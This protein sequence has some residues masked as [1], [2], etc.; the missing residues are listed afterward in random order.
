MKINCQT[1]QE[2]DRLL[3]ELIR[4]NIILKEEHSKMSDDKQDLVRNLD[5]IT[6]QCEKMQI[7]KRQAVQKFDLSFVV[8]KFHFFRVL[9]SQEKWNRR[10][11]KTRTEISS[12][13]SRDLQ[14]SNRTFGV[15][16]E[17]SFVESEK[18]REKW[19]S[20]SEVNLGEN[21]SRRWQR[22]ESI[23]PVEQ[24]RRRSRFEHGR[25]NER[26]EE[27]I[28]EFF[29]AATLFDA[30]ILQHFVSDRYSTFDHPRNCDRCRSTEDQQTKGS[31]VG[32]RCRRPRRLSRSAFGQ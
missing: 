10:E 16:T 5:R 20:T 18:C 14:I 22:R 4:Y 19:I 1:V 31:K 27:F 30:T 6:A 15:T 12:S 24:R 32:R 3:E 2:K 29:V 13:T 28:V 26:R 23:R 8:G 9:L 7:D 11:H 25:F 17:L 21:N